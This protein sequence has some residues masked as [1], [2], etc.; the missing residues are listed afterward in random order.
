MSPRLALLP[1]ALTL[2]AACGTATP[3]APADAA[4]ADAPRADVATDT[5]PA[6]DAAT[7]DDVPPCSVRPDA[8][9]VACVRRVRG[10]VV[11]FAGAA[12][13]NHVIT[14]CGP[15]C[16]SATTGADGAFVVEVNNFVAARE[17]TL[18]VHGRPAH[19]SAW[20]A[21][22]DPAGEEVTFPEAL[23][24]PRYEDVGT[25]IA[26]TA[27]GSY[28]AGDVTVTVPAGARVEFDV[29]DFELA[30]LGRTLRS[31]R[32]EMGRAPAFAREAGLS[33]VWALAPFNLLCDRPMAVRVANRAGLPAGSA[34]DFVVMGNEIVTPPITAGRPVVAAAGHVSA[35]GATI[36]TDPGAGVSYLTWIGVRPRR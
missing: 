10:R 31:T 7:D 29:E 13:A 27:P 4:P 25:E 14:Y 16:F 19:A 24:V 18:Q 26:Q 20:W 6:V 15:A 3:G 34:V 8:A 9:G 1:T 12:L 22:L 11:D 36:A 5:T 21:G 28:T 17:Y 35:D 23:A 2:L 30:A 32:V 33:A